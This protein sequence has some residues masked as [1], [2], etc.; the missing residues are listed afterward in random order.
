MHETV[1]YAI[2]G[3]W[4]DRDVLVGQPLQCHVGL[5]AADS[6]A[7]LQL[8]GG[9]SKAVQ[10]S[11]DGRMITTEATT[12]SGFHKIVLGSPANRTDWFAVNVDPTESDLT[13][14][15]VEDVR[16]ELMPGIEIAYLTEWEETSA[17]DGSRVRTISTGTGFSRMLLIAALMLLL[18]EQL[19]AWRF[20]PGMFLLLAILISMLNWCVWRVNS[21]AGALMLAVI[22]IGLVVLAKRSRLIPQPSDLA[23]KSAR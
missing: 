22:L 3:R 21:T 9:D 4:K 16:N 20:A 11:T 18:V 6:P 8:P 19:M 17:R 1:S 13:A 2:A 7:T 5:R 12:V 23:A 15:R 14:L 10:P